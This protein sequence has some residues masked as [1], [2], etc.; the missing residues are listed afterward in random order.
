MMHGN[1]DGVEKFAERIGGG[2]G[3]DFEVN[4]IFMKENHIKPKLFLFFTDG[5][6]FGSWGWPSYKTGFPTIFLISGNPNTDAPK[7]IGM[8]LH[9]EDQ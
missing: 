6:P 1:W 5:Y 4:W 3:T 2:G 7:S 9:Y 8:S